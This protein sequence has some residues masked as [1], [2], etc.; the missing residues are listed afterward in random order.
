MGRGLVKATAVHI[1]LAATCQFQ[2][3]EKLALAVG[4]QPLPPFQTY[5]C[6]SQGV[7]QGP[8]SW[9]GMGSL[10]VTGRAGQPKSK[11]AELSRIV[12]RQ[13]ISNRRCYCFSRDIKAPTVGKES[14]GE[15]AHPGTSAG[16]LDFP[17]WFLLC[18]VSTWFDNV[19]S[20]PCCLCLHME[21]S[22]QE[23][24]ALPWTLPAGDS[25]DCLKGACLPS[26]FL[27]PVSSHRFDVLLSTAH[28]LFFY[29]DLLYF[30]D[31]LI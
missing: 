30:T 27:L 8:L 25:V 26:C 11:N 9:D 13:I 16:C 6:L 28:H 5:T 20:I 23:T 14:H 1:T 4:M 10:T 18:V 17:S 12:R 22:L 2:L 29:V 15:K 7:L 31:S 21:A 19:I 3:S 24:S